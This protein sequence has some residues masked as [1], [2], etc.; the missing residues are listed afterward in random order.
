MK[1]KVLIDKTV[2]RAAASPGAG[3]T[4]VKSG[5]LTTSGD[6]TIPLISLGYM[7]AKG[8]KEK[9]FN[10]AGARTQLALQ[11][12]RRVWGSV[13]GSRCAGSGRSYASSCRTW[14]LA[15]T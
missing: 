10:P 7:C 3:G 6:A 2:N 8:W 13:R 11:A 4:T 14:A 1:P 12:A 9:R 15:S 5:V